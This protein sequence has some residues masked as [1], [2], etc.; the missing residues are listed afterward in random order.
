M[1]LWV[2]FLKTDYLKNSGKEKVFDSINFSVKLAIF[3]AP[4]GTVFIGHSVLC[5]WETMSLEINGI[6]GAIG[7]LVM[8]VVY[9][10]EHL[11]C[12]SSSPS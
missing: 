11:L 12:I 9:F 6:K 2:L 8:Q 10:I 7:P 5:P 3:M 1:S 4:W